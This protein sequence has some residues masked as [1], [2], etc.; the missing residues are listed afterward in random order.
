[1]SFP[2]TSVMAALIQQ[3]GTLLC[4]PSHTCISGASWEFSVAFHSWASRFTGTKWHGQQCS[5]RS[6]LCAVC[7]SD[8]ALEGWLAGKDWD[9]TWGCLNMSL[10]DWE[11]SPG[12]LVLISQYSHR[13]N[14]GCRITWQGAERKPQCLLFQ[15]RLIWTQC[16]SFQVIWKHLALKLEQRVSP[17]DNFPLGNKRQKGTRRKRIMRICWINQSCY[18]NFKNVEEIYKAK[19]LTQ[20]G[21]DSPEQILPVHSGSCVRTLRSSWEGRSVGMLW[22]QIMNTVRKK[23]LGDARKSPLSAEKNHTGYPSS[24]A[25]SLMCVLIQSIG[26]KENITKEEN[27]KKKK[28][29]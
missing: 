22:R 27:K 5:C 20:I 13:N 4:N 7:W 8:P 24:Q 18:L 6:L 2:I 28:E 17:S 26:R 25:L 16:Q 29:A 21:E 3:L 19:L 9:V 1:M 15:G 12:T 14:Q 11:L 23:Q 10:R